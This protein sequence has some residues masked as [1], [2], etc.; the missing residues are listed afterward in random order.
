MRRR[1]LLYSGA[2]LVF[3]PAALQSADRPNFTGTW[4]ADIARSNFGPMPPPQSL[5][6]VVQHKEP[7][8]EVKTTLG[9]PRGD[10]ILVTKFTTDGAESVNSVPNQ[11]DMR[12]TAAWDGSILRVTTRR[13]IRDVEHV[14]EDR[15]SL[16]E[17]R[18]LLTIDSQVKS[19]T[20]TV[21]LKLVLNKQG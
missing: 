5:V 15:W 8:I 4:K 17:N 11:D 10:R 14:Q 13:M 18:T 19:P 6:R 2:S 7:A 12:T 9:S 20:G 21:E 16:T 3:A 1:T